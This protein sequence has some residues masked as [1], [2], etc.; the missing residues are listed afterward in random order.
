ML[1]LLAFGYYTNYQI[2]TQILFTLRA[3][4]NPDKILGMFTLANFFI[5]EEGL[6]P[7]IMRA[8]PF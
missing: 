7:C 3:L 6:A 4:P 5:Q 1:S 8:P 2:P